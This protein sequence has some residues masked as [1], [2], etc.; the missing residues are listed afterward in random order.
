[1]H[2]HPLPQFDRRRQ[3]QLEVR[4]PVRVPGG[5]GEDCDIAQGVSVQLGRVGEQDT[6]AARVTGLGR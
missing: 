1:M 4:L 5:G 2:R 3:L 6:G